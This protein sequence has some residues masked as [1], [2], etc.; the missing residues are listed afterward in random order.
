LGNTNHFI[1]HQLRLTD[2]MGKRE[3]TVYISSAVR[4]T[5]RA[6]LLG[7]K[8]MKAFQA[9]T[10]TLLR[11]V[12]MA[13]MI[14]VM[15]VGCNYRVD[16]QAAPGGRSPIGEAPRGGTPGGG[17][18]K[19]TG[20]PV[21]FQKVV[22][23][24]LRERCIRCHSKHDWMNDYAQ[25]RAS[26]ASIEDEVG[27]GRMPKGK[28]LTAEEKDLLLGW[29]RAGA[30]Q[31]VEAAPAPA[32][33]KTATPNPAPTPEAKPTPTPPA[34]PAPTP[35]ASATPKVKLEPTYASLKVLIFDPRCV[36]CHS[37]EGTANLYPLDSHGN[38][39]LQT[40]LIDR[41]NP[42]KSVLVE[43]VTREKFQ[44]PPAK[45][46]YPRLSDDEVKVLTEWI[47]LGLPE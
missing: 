25:V 12:I 26:L 10:L 41:T 28:P 43:A 24:V 27:S 2:L 11:S 40:D 35:A 23:G 44:M 21:D 36:S 15:M 17:D 5:S 3:R 39:V 34:S 37:S 13:V 7:V 20:S 22:A 46:G 6:V 18:G 16:K 32:P 1:A 8:T 30:P 29:I 47:R 38:I 33:E 45:S 4:E 9:A 14:A 31:F 42:G 19:G